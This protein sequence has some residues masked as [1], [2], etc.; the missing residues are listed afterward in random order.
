MSTL[1]SATEIETLAKGYGLTIPALCRAASVP[2][3]T[4]YRWRT[5]QGSPSMITYGRLMF[6]LTNAEAKEEGGGT[7]DRAAFYK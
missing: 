1:L 7:H 6:A 4:F 2:I 5:G 3:S